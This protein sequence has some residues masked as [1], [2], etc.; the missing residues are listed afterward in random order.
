[1]H[2]ICTYADPTRTIL[3]T[4]LLTVSDLDAC[5][6]QETLTTR[7]QQVIRHGEQ[8]RA[9]KGVFRVLPLVPSATGGGTTTAVNQK[10]KVQPSAPEIPVGEAATAV[11][12]K[13][14]NQA[15]PLARES[16]SGGGAA[17]TG[18]NQ[19]AQ[20]GLSASGSPGTTRGSQS[21]EKVEGLTPTQGGRTKKRRRR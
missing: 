17:T 10:G 19:K 6:P 7:P 18:V 9:Y 2:N 5:G 21:A 8:R 12:Q 15:S 16:A 20:V 14:R 3:R 1:M 11:Q 4:I 13:E